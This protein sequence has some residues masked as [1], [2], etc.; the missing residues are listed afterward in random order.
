MALT[1]AQLAAM[2]RRTPT[3]IAEDAYQASRP[4]RRHPDIVGPAGVPIPDPRTAWRVT[5]DPKLLDRILRAAFADH[6]AAILTGA[7]HAAMAEALADALVRDFPPSDMIVLRRYGLADVRGRTFVDMGRYG[8]RTV[9]LPEPLLLPNGKGG[10]HTGGR[11]SALSSLPLPEAALPF[12]DDL[13]ALEDAKGPEFMDA[14]HCPGQFKLR[15]GRWP[16]WGEIE[17]AWPRIG[18]WMAQERAAAG[19]ERK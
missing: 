3:E 17:A 11:P 5:T 14:H 7:R 1:P 6:R 2:P 18:A 15:E 4:I 10:F 13:A 8:Q 16:T 9:E 12:F 19:N